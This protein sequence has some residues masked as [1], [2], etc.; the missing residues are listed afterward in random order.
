MAGY[1]RVPISKLCS[2]ADLPEGA[3]QCKQRERLKVGFGTHPL[4][5]HGLEPV[6]YLRAQVKEPRKATSWKY[7]PLV[8]FRRATLPSFQKTRV[9]LPGGWWS[10]LPSPPDPLALP[11]THPR[12]WNTSEGWMSPSLGSIPPWKTPLHSHAMQTPGP[13]PSLVSPLGLSETWVI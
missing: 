7:S 4:S 12:V 1:R 2:L 5:T 9:F 8:D 13:R 11:F 10:V 3:Q 6:S